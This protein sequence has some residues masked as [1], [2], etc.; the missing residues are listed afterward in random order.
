MICTRE[1]FDS[2]SVYVKNVFSNHSIRRHSEQNMELYGVDYRTRASLLGKKGPD[3]V[4]DTMHAFNSLQS[5]FRTT[6]SP[7]TS[8]SSGNSLEVLEPEET[9][10]SDNNFYN[11]FHVGNGE[12]AEDQLKSNITGLHEKLRQQGLQHKVELAEKDL[13]IAQIT[14]ERDRLLAEKGGL[15]QVWANFPQIIFCQT[16][17]NIDPTNGR[18]QSGKMWREGCRHC[19]VTI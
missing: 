16:F 17:F 10:D 8:K 1:K 15:S 14:L 19:N 4:Q 9:P 3:V 6:V 12:L 2:P 11:N 5:G 13:K 7:T 18:K